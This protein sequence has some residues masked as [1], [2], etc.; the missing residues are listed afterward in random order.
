MMM[1]VVMAM[2]VMK[3]M[4]VMAV[5]VMKMMM[6]IVVVLLLVVMIIMM[7][8]IWWWWFSGL[9]KGPEYEGYRTVSFGRDETE[10]VPCEYMF[11][12]SGAIARPPL[13]VSVDSYSLVSV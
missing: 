1:I 8:I 10:Q 6:L 12:I 2:V 7:M 13:H 11:N 5:V 9:A 4:M 3:M